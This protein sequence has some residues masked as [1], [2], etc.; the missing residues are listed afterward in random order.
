MGGVG[1]RGA[2]AMTPGPA[3]TPGVGGAASRGD[4]AG[5]Q[6]AEG[7]GR[8]WGESGALGMGS[9]V[10]Q[11]R[12]RRQV[13]FITFRFD[14]IRTPL[15]HPVF[16]ALLSPPLFCSVANPTEHLPWSPQAPAGPL[17][18]CPP[19]FTGWVM[20]ADAESPLGAWKWSAGQ[21]LCPHP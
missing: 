20:V 18:V 13:Y 7:S 19:P 3:G 9:L 16:A 2:G 12:S 5:P 8:L 10:L 15:G 14:F 17:G 11:W 1:R 4:Q 21:K 6:R